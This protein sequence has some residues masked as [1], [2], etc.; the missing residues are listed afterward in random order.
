MK[1]KAFTLAEIM[2]VLG[3]IGVLTAILLPV[4]LQST[5]NENV[6]KFK[7]GHNALLTT[8]RELVNSDE[9]YLDGDLS[10][11]NNGVII[12]DSTTKNIKYFCN[13]FADI[14]SVKKV[15]CST[16]ELYDYS[17]ITLSTLDD[18]DQ[19]D[20]MCKNAA[21]T[22]DEEIVTLDGIVYYQGSPGTPFG[23][24]YYYLDGTKYTNGESSCGIK[25]LFKIRG[26]ASDCT[27]YYTFPISV[28]KTF[29][30]DIDGIG[31]G[32]DPFGYGIRVDG[33]VLF[34]T[35]AQEWLQKSIQE[36]E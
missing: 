23:V 32:E 22:I 7:K 31:K 20:D 11:M 21:E 13:S 1:S 19:S 9:Y 27:D 10:V 8:I 35:R 6:M 26:E 2:I 17:H 29:C 36:K 16:K 25:G 14:V 33:K 28:Y 24:Q 34:G 12:D 15:K 3:V 18:S 5:P 4:A 30:M